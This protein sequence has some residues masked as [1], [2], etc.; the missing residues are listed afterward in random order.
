MTEAAPSSLIV[1][2]N[3]YHV[4]SLARLPGNTMTFTFTQRYIDDQHRPTLSWGFYDAY[5]R[6]RTRQISSGLG[7]VPPFFSNLLPEGDLRRYVAR[8]SGVGA[9][10]DFA[11]LW[12]TGDDLPGA[13]T[14][15]D[16]H[17]RPLP[18]A[19][20]GGPNY[21]IPVGEL[22]RF[23]LAGVQLKFSA[24]ERA[25]GGLTIRANGRDGQWIVKLPSRHLDRVPEN[26]YAMLRYAARVGIDIPEI[27]LVDSQA[28]G[29]LPEEAEALTGIALGIRRFDRLADGT[30]VH[31]EDFNQIYRQPP[32]EKYNNRSFASIAETIYQ[33]LGNE[34]LIDF[35][36]RLVFN[37]GIANNDMHLKNWSF[38]YRDGRA[39]ALAPAYDYVCTKAY[40][41][42][43]ETGLPIGSARYFAAVTIEQFE[44]LAVRARVSRNVVQRAARDMVAR[45]R[46]AWRDVRDELPLEAMRETIEQQFRTV[47]LFNNG[48][49]ALS[50]GPARD[51]P[52]REVS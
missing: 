43:S 51:V 18:P 8:R 14:L 24:I 48:T 12:V 13:V 19:A 28:I 26:E 35:I 49:A 27:R 17:G 3:D 30:R 21:D 38:I 31:I 5:G 50:L 7:N 2:L 11:M 45:M 34:A 52:H 33:A 15:S 22:L 9:T 41:E 46:E 36:H 39:P 10:D 37:I 29:G 4:G 20:D 23:S 16:P 32:N 44:N 1:R 47:P 42:S 25:Y 6:L 40:L